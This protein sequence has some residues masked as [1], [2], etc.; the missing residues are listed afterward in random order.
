MA[1]YPG[2]IAGRMAAG[3]TLPNINDALGNIVVA[4]KNEDGQG[5]TT[6]SK[7]ARMAYYAQGVHGLGESSPSQPGDARTKRTSLYQTG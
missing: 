7:L 3:Q 5:D 2:S 4:S 1:K 6:I